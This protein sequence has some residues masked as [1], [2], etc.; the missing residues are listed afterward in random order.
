MDIMVA[1]VGHEAVHGYLSRAP[2][3]GQATI[4]FSCLVS[5]DLSRGSKITV[6]LE[7]WY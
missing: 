3:R 2:C 7:L 4:E 1:A 5:L 6:S